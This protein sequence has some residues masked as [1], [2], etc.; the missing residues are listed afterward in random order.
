MP[1]RMIRDG[2]LESEAVLS[3]PVEARWLYVTILLSADDVG[4]FEATPFK[5][6][7][8]A[9]VR[10]ELADRLMT[11]LADSDL[12]RLYE[13]K[14]KRFGFIPRFG[15]RLQIKRIKH[16]A[17]PDALLS[18]EP[19]TL[20][21]I[22]DL[23]SKTTVD[24]GCASAGQRKSTVAQRPEPEPEPEVE[25]KQP[26]VISPKAP[27]KR[28]TLAM[29]IPDWIDSKAWGDYEEMRRSIRKPMTDAARV[30]AIKTL[31]DLERDG[32][33]NADVLAQSVMNSWQ[34]LFQIK[35]KGGGY[36][37]RRPQQSTEDRDA[38]AM[39]LLGFSADQADSNF[40]TFEG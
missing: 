39:R 12:V 4:L 28:S 24:H 18:D 9:D 13:V 16:A 6:A 19:D 17:P 40:N 30:I 22:K 34:G 8:I 14:G 7:R 37:A 25:E 2:I 10:R 35:Q 38:E 20:N 36:S 31:A 15:Q 32:H 29:A 21:K 27:R 23:A 1:N 26:S 5:L 11:M 33:K 3:L